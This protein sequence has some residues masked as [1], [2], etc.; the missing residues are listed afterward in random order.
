MIYCLRSKS[1]WCYLFSVIIIIIHILVANIQMTIMATSLP[2][3]AGKIVGRLTCNI[4]SRPVCEILG[5]LQAVGHLMVE[6]AQ[7]SL[8][9]EFLKNMQLLAI[10]CCYFLLHFHHLL[11]DLI[12]SWIVNRG[13]SPSVFRILVFV[14][15]FIVSK[16]NS[17]LTM[18][19]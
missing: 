10:D 4:V 5:V 1:I 2:V 15:L 9:L 8:V 3:T 7:S 17:Q 12:G 6:V 19:I 16:T 18:S 13:P 11:Q 14:W